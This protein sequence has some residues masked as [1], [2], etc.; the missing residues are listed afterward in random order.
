MSWLSVCSEEQKRRTTGGGALSFRGAMAT[1]RRACACPPCDGGESPTLLPTGPLESQLLGFLLHRPQ[2]CSSETIIDSSFPMESTPT[3]PAVNHAIEVHLRSQAAAADRKARQQLEAAI[4][5]TKRREASEVEVDKLHHENRQLQSEISHLKAKLH[6]EQRARAGA[7]RVG[8]DLLSDL[9]QYKKQRDY[10]QDQA[11][12]AIGARDTALTTAIALRDCLRS[13]THSSVDS[14]VE[15]VA[16]LRAQLIQC[17]SRKEQ[18]K[19]R[20]ISETNRADSLQLRCDTL[21]R[22]V[23]ALRHEVAALASPA[24]GSV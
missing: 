6:D 9:E 19:Q 11:Q 13:P 10:W 15:T 24:R 1:R 22:E 23:S 18:H 20:A 14:S 2:S 5:E 12:R 16:L 21:E 3:M 17:R 7:A 4:E 8:K